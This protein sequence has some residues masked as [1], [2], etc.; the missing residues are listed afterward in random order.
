MT[1][2]FG[3]RAALAGALT[4]LALGAGTAVGPAAADADRGY[5]S[6][7][8]VRILYGTD[9]EADIRASSGPGAAQAPQ[10]APRAAAPERAVLASRRSGITIH[11]A[12]RAY[13]RDIKVHR[14]G[15]GGANVIIHRAGID[16]SGQGRRSTVRIHRS[17]EPKL[18][19]LRIH[20]SGEPKLGLLRIHRAGT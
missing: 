15:E 14:G 11:R 16:R 19:L 4:A 1:K 8:G 12:G 3:R 6:P 5:E 18:G 13:G 2:H 9:P 20:R 7:S 17:G 10:A